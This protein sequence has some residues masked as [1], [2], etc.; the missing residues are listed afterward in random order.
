MESD[1][2]IWVSASQSA[3]ATRDLEHAMSKKMSESG[4][5]INPEL[6]YED[7][8]DELQA[9]IERIETGQIGLEQSMAQYERGAALY[10]HCK[11][12]QEQ[13]EQKFSDLTQ[14]MQ[15]GAAANDPKKPA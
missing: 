10:Q 14:Q 9:I 7:A 12:I 13:V 6:S 2:R 4:V 5:A 15:A 3:A 8:R 1:S 11:R